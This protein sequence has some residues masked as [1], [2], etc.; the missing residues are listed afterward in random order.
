MAGPFDAVRQQFIDTFGGDGNI[1][2]VRAPGRVNLI[3]EHT[4]Y[5]DG[6]VF[7]MAIDRETVVAGARRDERRVRVHSLNFNESAEFD[8]DEEGKAQRGLWLGYVE[9]TARELEKFGKRLHGA[10]LVIASN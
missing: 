6:F 9:G 4:D 2:V 7:P 8:L 5:N 3:G 10:G 1:H